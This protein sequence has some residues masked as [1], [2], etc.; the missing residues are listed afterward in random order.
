MTKPPGYMFY[1]DKWASHTGHLSDRS[2][3]IYHRMLNLMWLQGDN[4]YSIKKDPSFLAVALC[5]TLPGIE[6]ALAEIQNEHMPLLKEDETHFISNGLKKEREGQK[7]RSKQGS[8]A[9]KERYRKQ[10]EKD[11]K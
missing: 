1:P 3:R 9:A 5:E 11:G 6:V 8:D 4:Q 2:Y 10:R 7:K